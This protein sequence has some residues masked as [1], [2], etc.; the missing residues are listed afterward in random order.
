MSKGE[1]PLSPDGF[2]DCVIG[3]SCNTGPRALVYSIQ[4]M[5]KKLVDIDEMTEEEAV[6]FLSY[7]TLSSWGG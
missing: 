7:N 2:E 1:Y 3:V 4:R 6:E 5:T